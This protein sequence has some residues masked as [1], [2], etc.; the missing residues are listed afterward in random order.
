MPAELVRRG[1]ERLFRRVLAR[2]PLP[3]ESAA[4]SRALA[5]FRDRFRAAPH[6]AVALLAAGEAPRD[7]RLDEAELAAWT[8]LASS[9]LNL[10][11]ATNPR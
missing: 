6:K 5:D 11:E 1:L 3:E 9:T 8:F 2:D 10:F 4:L 7:P